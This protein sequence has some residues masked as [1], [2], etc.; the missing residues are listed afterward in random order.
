M[1]LLFFFSISKT[2]QGK[3]YELF[4][5]CCGGQQLQVYLHH[6]FGNVLNSQ[7]PDSVWIQA[8]GCQLSLQFKD[9]QLKQWQ[10][11]NEFISLK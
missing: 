4:A 11:V 2:L 3:V 9:K 1:L 8:S 6:G 7:L 5:F 10:D